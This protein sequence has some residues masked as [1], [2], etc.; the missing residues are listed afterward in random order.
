MYQWIRLDELYKLMESFFQISNSFA[1][2]LDEKRRIYSN[3]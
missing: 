1:E 2:L 3:E